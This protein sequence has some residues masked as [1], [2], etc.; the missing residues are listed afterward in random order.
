MAAH[1]RL[2]AR[3]GVDLDRLDAGLAMVPLELRRVD[4]RLA[5]ERFD[6]LV[7]ELGL[8]AERLLD[9]SSGLWRERVRTRG[10]HGAFLRPKCGTSA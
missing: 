7:V 9:D 4:E 3:T 6:N 1:S 10:N 2:R 5:L 8:Q